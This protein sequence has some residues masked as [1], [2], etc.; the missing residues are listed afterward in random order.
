MALCLSVE[1]WRCRLRIAVSKKIVPTP[2]G[3]LVWKEDLGSKED[4]L[5]IPDKR[6][7]VSSENLFVLR[8]VSFFLESRNLI[9][10]TVF[11]S[12]GVP[13]YRVKRH[14]HPYQGTG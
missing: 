10:A 6:A 7:C 3:P 9:S 12:G 1:R 8:A 14:S 2:S 11:L 13:T 4:C 5:L